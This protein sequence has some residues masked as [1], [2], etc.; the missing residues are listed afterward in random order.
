V[1]WQWGGWVS[2]VLVLF[3]G[4]RRRLI[5]GWFS[6]L[7]TILCF[8]SA[9]TTAGTGGDVSVNVSVIISRVVGYGWVA[10]V[11]GDRRIL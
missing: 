9:L 8:G 4:Q 1:S 11:Q 6:P 10:G 3:V 2:T 7:P 5:L